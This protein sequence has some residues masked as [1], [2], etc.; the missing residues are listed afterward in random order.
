[1]ASGLMMTS[2]AEF[3]LHLRQDNA[4]IRLCEIGRRV[5][6]VDDKRWRL[7]KKKL[8][9][10]RRLKGMLNTA[11]PVCQKKFEVP[12]MPL[13]VLIKRHDADFDFIKGLDIVKGISAPALLEVFIAL[14][15]E[16]YLQREERARHEQARLEEAELPQDFD[17]TCVSGLRK[18]AAEKL[19]KVKPRSV[20]QAGRISGVNPA[21]ID[22]LLVRLRQ[23]KG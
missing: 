15:Y 23:I 8:R 18:E 19:N 11:V 4:D 2:R 17:Y 5:G 1:V 10:I 22:I 14:R 7:F 16:G 13:K 3:R 21:D 20:A 9:D 12:A 6:L